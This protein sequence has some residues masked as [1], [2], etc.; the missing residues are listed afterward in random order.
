MLGDIVGGKRNAVREEEE[1]AEEDSEFQWSSDN[2]HRPP[3]A[4]APSSELS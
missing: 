3:G 4:R 2:Q 1:V